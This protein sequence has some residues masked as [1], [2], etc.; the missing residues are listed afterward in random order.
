MGYAQFKSAHKDLITG[1]DIGPGQIDLRHLSAALFAK[2]K[3][4]TQHVHSGAD[5]RKIRL[6]D[7]EGSF[8]KNGF[9]IY[10]SDG[11]KRYR[12]QVTSGG[13]LSLTEA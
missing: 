6:Q 12:L 4:V 3:K 2:L 1:D 8:G 11:T 10:S 9:L 7:L 13:A 5:S